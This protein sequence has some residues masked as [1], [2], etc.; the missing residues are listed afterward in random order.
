MYL[1]FMNLR[2]LQKKDYNDFFI[3]INDFRETNFS[4][5]DFNNLLET[6]KNTEIYILE[7]N[8]KIIGAGTLLFE[9]KFIHNISLYAHIE[10]I[11]IKKEYQ[12]KGYGKILLLEL[13]NICKNKNCFK[14]LLDCQEN[15]IKFYE[16]CGF[17]NKGYQMV[18]YF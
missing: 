10:D 1:S 2:L 17:Q 15:L 3:L 5:D 7:I 8:N 18:I 4:Y 11:I 13:I 12:G 14:I 16:N 6:Q 9:K